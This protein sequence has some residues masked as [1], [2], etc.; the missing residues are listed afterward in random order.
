[1][2]KNSGRSNVNSEEAPGISQ[3]DLDIRLNP[4]VVKP[5]RPPPIMIKILQNAF[6]PPASDTGTLL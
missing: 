2:V 3:V 1:L 4:L 5:Y 6:L